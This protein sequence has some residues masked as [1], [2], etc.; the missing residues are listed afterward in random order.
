LLAQ[1]VET[2]GYSTTNF[3]QASTNFNATAYPGGIFGNVNTSAW[4]SSF[5]APQRRGE[6]RVIAIKFM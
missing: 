3:G 2:R 4:G 5:T 1:D 6:A